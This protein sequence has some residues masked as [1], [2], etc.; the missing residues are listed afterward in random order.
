MMNAVGGTSIHWCAQAWRLHPDDFRVRTNTIAKY[1]ESALPTGTDIQDWPI[2]YDDLEPYYDKVEYTTGVSGKAGNIKGQVIEG[3]NVFEGAR[4]REYP[5]PPLPDF[6]LGS[7]FTQATKKMG[8]HPFPGAAGIISA[9]M[10]GVR[11]ARFAAGA[12]ATAVTSMPR[13]APSFRPYPK[14]SPPAILTCAR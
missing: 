5:L 7:L 3:G 13:P 11:P 6:C 12:A 1:G 10:T 8:Y 4:Q 9:T 14:L 2:S